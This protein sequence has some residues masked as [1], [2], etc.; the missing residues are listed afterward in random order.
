[1]RLE[2]WTI[3][4]LMGKLVCLERS[5]TSVHSKLLRLL[6]WACWQF[7]TVYFFPLQN[8]ELKHTHTKQTCVFVSNIVMLA[9]Q[10]ADNQSG[11]Q[12]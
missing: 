6:R 1:M 4:N 12:P 2:N 5:P 3:V 9:T 7:E 8:Q 11:M 10:F